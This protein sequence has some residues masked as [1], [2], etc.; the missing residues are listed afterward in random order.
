MT[1]STF[2]NNSA[3]YGGAINAH[4]ADIT[5]SALTRNTALEHG[6]AVVLETAEGVMR[7][8]TFSRNSAL[9]GG[10]AISF[11]SVSRSAARRLLATNRFVG[12]RGKTRANQH[13]EAG[14]WDCF[15]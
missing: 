8:N 7:R 9:N 3:D 15:D 12:N 11:C 13:I 4:S 5:S 14:G 2:T 10:G 1:L 6:G